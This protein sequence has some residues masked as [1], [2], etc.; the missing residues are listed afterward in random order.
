MKVE[1]TLNQKRIMRKSAQ[2]LFI[3]AVLSIALSSC[4]LFGGKKGPCPA[5]GKADN[6]K[7]TT[8]ST[9]K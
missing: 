2:A 3:G 7:P 5:Y 6:L 1:K 8:E 9:L 4:G